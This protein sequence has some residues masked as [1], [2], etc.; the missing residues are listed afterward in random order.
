MIF[1][2]LSSLI[3][4]LYTEERKRHACRSNFIAGQYKELGELYS[5]RK[6]KKEERREENEN[7]CSKSSP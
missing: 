5:N 6:K 1:P 3:V 4:S 2:V 7:I